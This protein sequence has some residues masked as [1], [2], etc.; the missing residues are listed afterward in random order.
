M[1]APIRLLPPNRHEEHRVIGAGLSC[2]RTSR[3]EKKKKAILVT[4]EMKQRASI[5]LVILCGFPGNLVLGVTSPKAPVLGPATTVT[6]VQK[7]E[8]QVL[9]LH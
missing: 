5:Y 3:L 8:S 4:R 7:A 6:P 9:Q 2:A 1:L